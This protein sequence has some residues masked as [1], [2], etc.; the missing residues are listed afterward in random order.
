MRSLFVLLIAFSFLHQHFTCCCETSL[1]SACGAEPV[2][3]HDLE[4]SSECEHDHESAR[5][6][7]GTELPQTADHHGPHDHHF[8]VGSHLFYLTSQDVPL[9]LSP[10]LSLIPVICQVEELLGQYSE[11]SLAFALRVPDDPL[12]SRELRAQ[13]CVYSI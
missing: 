2:C 3:S 5:H 12:S 10:Q 13:L 6:E 7:H 9:D 1:D 4:D 11:R 8:C